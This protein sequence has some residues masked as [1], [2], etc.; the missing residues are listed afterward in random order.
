MA[1]HLLKI[2]QQF[3]ALRPVL[4]GSCF[5]VELA[6]RSALKFDI[7]PFESIPRLYLSPSPCALLKNFTP[8]VLVSIFCCFLN[9]AKM[10]FV[11]SNVALLARALE[12]LVALLFPFEWPHI[13][14][15]LLP[16]NLLDFFDAPLPYVLGVHS[17]ALA[18][19]QPPP[20]AVIVE[21]D[22]GSI[23]LRT[24]QVVPFSLSTY[25]RLFDTFA[26]LLPPTGS[27]KPP[28]FEAPAALARAQ[29][30]SRYSHVFLMDAAEISGLPSFC[31]AEP[32]LSEFSDAEQRKHSRFQ[33]Q[34]MRCWA[35]MLKTHRFFMNFPTSSTTFDAFFDLD[36]FLDTLPQAE[37][38]FLKMLC[39]TQ[40]FQL[41][42]QTRTANA[43]RKEPPDL[44][45]YET[46][47]IAQ[48]QSNNLLALVHDTFS[49]QGIRISRRRRGGW[50]WTRVF[51]Y[52]TAK[53]MKVSSK[54][55]SVC[56]SKKPL[57]LLDEQVVVL[58][59]DPRSF[60]SRKLKSLGDHSLGIRIH[61]S[62]AESQL[63][64][65]DSPAVH[66][67]F[68]HQ[69]QS[70]TLPRD[71]AAFRQ[72]QY[73]L[74]S[75]PRSHSSSSQRAHPKAGTFCFE[76]LETSLE[77]ASRNSVSSED[78]TLLLSSEDKDKSAADLPERRISHS[79]LNKPRSK[80]EAFGVHLL[81]VDEARQWFNLQPKTEA[82]A[83]PIA[84]FQASSAAQQSVPSSS[85]SITISESD[86]LHVVPHE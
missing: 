50:R 28:A 43:L 38:T 76:V 14:V 20:D 26:E 59:E 7:S 42:V 51:I 54:S 39:Q 23:S 83:S 37:T 44:F 45:D 70:R 1:Q 15:P 62:N 73:E 78:V 58:D 29:E 46:N 55:L 4:S 2:F 21:Y 84:Q 56:I 75:R 85:S 64:V 25:R 79:Y 11:S 8:A 57:L 52:L 40:L 53:E 18:I 12:L 74:P 71:F 86:E 19:R 36:T 69:L 3:G 30:S 81:S 48:E 6:D 77:S 13:Y 65:F 10:V 31:F 9:E 63:F 80:L 5:Q 66:F 49:G 60:C 22:S 32:D 41:F 35:L 47:R 61:S 72:Q 16:L 67:Q 17:D 27:V 24:A 82:S 34:T 33:T 68:L